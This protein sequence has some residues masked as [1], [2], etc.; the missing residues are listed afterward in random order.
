M[1]DQI[2]FNQE[3]LSVLLDKGA[4]IIHLFNNK[5]YIPLRH[6]GKKYIGIG[7]AVAVIRSSEKVD[8]EELNISFQ[9]VKVEKIVI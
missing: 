3:E 7:D 5:F 8:L 2:A 1:L 4:T 9:N 6:T